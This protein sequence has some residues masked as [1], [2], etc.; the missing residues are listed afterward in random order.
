MG[1]RGLG[2]ATPNIGATHTKPASAAFVSAR[3][4]ERLPDEPCL[5]FGGRGGAL[6][7]KA[8]CEIEQLPV[9]GFR[10]AHE[11]SVRDIERCFM[12]RKSRDHSRKSS[13]AELTRRENRKQSAGSL[14]MTGMPS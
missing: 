2:D 4:A 13:A 9:E 7:E 14:T 1:V 5:G 10:L 12:A 6:S 11:L 8:S 3:F